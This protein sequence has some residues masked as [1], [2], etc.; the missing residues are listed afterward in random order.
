MHIAVIGV[1]SV[2][3]T[4]GV[5]LAVAG[6][7]VTMGTRDP[8]GERAVAARAELG[9]RVTIDT[10]VR[11]VRTASIVIFAIPGTAMDTT[12]AALAP[13]LAGKVVIDA[14]NRIGARL[15]DRQVMNSAAAFAEHAPTA[16]VFRAFNS[17][18]WENFAEPEVR[19]VQADLLYAGPDGADRSAVERIIGDI[20]LRPVYVG[21]AET[22]PL[23]DALGALWGAL[24]F[25]RGMG[26][27]L[28]FKVVTP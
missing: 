10:M 8:A 18:G 24:A 1:G 4:L 26:R 13:D 23:V 6:H 20:G 27:R 19:G 3:A 16:A 11:A 25:G 17:L 9:D 12:V 21:G 7:E 2:G 14:T 22:V 5:R 15:G 28:F